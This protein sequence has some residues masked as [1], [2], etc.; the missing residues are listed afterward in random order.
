M[1]GGPH[2]RNM[3]LAKPLAA[4]GVDTVVL[5]PDEPGNAAQRLGKAGLEV[6]QCPLSRLRNTRNPKLLIGFAWS[7]RSDIRRIREIIRNEHI[8]LV[9]LNGLV[10]PHAAI[11]ARLEGVPVVWQIVDTYPPMALRRLAALFVRR[12]ATVTM[13]TGEH[14]A[15]VHPGILTAKN[16]MV[17]FYPPVDLQRFTSKPSVR[18]AAR[19]E[20]SLEDTSL[21]VGTVGNI[22]LQKGHDSFIRAAALLRQQVPAAK[23]VI[24]GAV[25]DNHQGYIQDLWSLATSVGLEVGR[26]LIVRD[27]QG[28]V[29]ELAQAFD[30][31]WMTSEPNSE[32]IPTA[33]EEAMALGLPVVSFDVGS[34]GELVEHGI[35]GYLVPDQNVEAMV[36]YTVRNLLEAQQRARMGQNGRGFVACNASLEECTRRHIKAYS[37]ALGRYIGTDNQMASVRGAQTSATDPNL[38]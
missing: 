5:L 30:I 16:R 26:D 29:D 1:F 10:N 28:R 9:Q 19:A 11:A 36:D 33:M 24:L 35:S 3:R 18:A 15:R 38:S 27:P 2:N 20:L 34:I 17:L 25:H 32:G 21:V 7:L 12:L 23:F 37:L 8:N 6:V 14:V 31:F 4:R 13:C 22:N